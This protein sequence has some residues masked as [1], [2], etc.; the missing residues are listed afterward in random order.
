MTTQRTG[1]VGLAVLVMVVACEAEPDD[2]ALEEVTVRGLVENGFQLNGFQLNG[3]QLN[4]FQLNGERLDGAPGT[5]DYIQLMDIDL[6]GGD[7]GSETWLVGSELS[8]KATNG[9]VSSGTALIDA[10][11]SF[12]HQEGGKGKKLKGVRITDVQPLAPGSDVML[13]TLEIKKKPL[14]ENGREAIL[15][16]DLWDPASG[17]RITDASDGGLTFACRGAALAKC[18]EYGYRPWASAAGVSLRDYHEACT[19]MVRADYCGDGTPHTTDGTPIH[20]VDKLGVQQV[21]PN[22]NYVVEAEW[23][24]DGAVCLN[25]ANTRHANQVLGCSIPACGPNFSSGGL[26]QSGKVL[27]AP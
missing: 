16:G 24:P 18:V 2:A 9:V 5:T 25:A 10:Q 11:I 26:V 7:K 6:K 14:C 23:G 8:I 15:L 17:D 22:V 19:R 1:L 12:D 27:A 3:F 21:D 20:V 4:G 13:Y